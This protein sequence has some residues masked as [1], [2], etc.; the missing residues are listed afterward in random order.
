VRGRSWAVSVGH[1]HVG[2][3]GGCSIVGVVCRGQ[4]RAETHTLCF[5]PDALSQG[6][7]TWS[8]RRVWAEMLVVRFCVQTNCTV[9]TLSA[10]P[11]GCSSAILLAPSSPTNT[12][13]AGRGPLHPPP[14]HRQVNAISG[15]FCGWSD[16]GSGEAAAAT[17]LVRARAC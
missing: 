16:S 2:T 1:G 7:H 6:P 9:S 11:C 10:P 15:V 3:C 13:S 5:Q 17:E 12:T 14:Q 4:T 8:R